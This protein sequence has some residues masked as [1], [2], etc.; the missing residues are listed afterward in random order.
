MSGIII[1]CARCL[2][3]YEPMHSDISCRRGGARSTNR[4]EPSVSCVPT[5]R[6]SQ[7]H[8]R[9]SRL[10]GIEGKGQPLPRVGQAASAAGKQIDAASRDATTPMSRF[11]QAAAKAEQTTAKLGISASAVGKVLG[12]GV[13]AGLLLS[14]KAAAD[15]QVSQERL[16]TTVQAQCLGHFQFRVMARNPS[17]GGCPRLGRPATLSADT[18][19]KS[20]ATLAQ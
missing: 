15:A 1:C 4:F 13:S 5:Q 10:S 2:C 8:G 19:A 18:H 3:D 12:T 14:V 11:E 9:Q 6:S 17:F 20:S 7:R 16:Q